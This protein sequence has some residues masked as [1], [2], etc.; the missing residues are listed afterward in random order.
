MSSTTLP[1]D[2]SSRREEST[3]MGSALLKD[4][5]KVLE[6]LG[7]L[8]LTCVMFALSMVIV[9]VG[10]LAQSRRDVWQVMEQY[11]RTWVAKIDVQDLFPPSMF[12]TLAQHYG[13]EDFGAMMASMLGPFQSLPFPGGWTI[14]LIMLINLTAAHSLKFKVRARGLKLAAGIVLT[15]VGMLLTYAVVVTGNMQMGVDFE[16]GRAHV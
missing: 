13:V 15:A 14:G 5:V 10:S 16:I 4:F 11:F 7:S 2:F 1:G 6:V 3:S 8:K 9:F 12:S